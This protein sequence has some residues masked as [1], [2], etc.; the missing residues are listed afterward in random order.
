MG[1]VTLH[2]A[3]R[4]I[5]TCTPCLAL[6]R[7]ADGLT[8]LIAVRIIT[9]PA[10]LGSTRLVIW[11][12]TCTLRAANVMS[13]AGMALRTP[14]L[15]EHSLILH[16][17]TSS[18]ESWT[19]L[20]QGRI[21]TPRDRNAVHGLLLNGLTLL[22]LCIRGLE[23]MD[24]QGTLHEIACFLRRFLSFPQLLFPGLSCRRQSTVAEVTLTLQRGSG[25]LQVPFIVCD[26][27][28]LHPVALCQLCLVEIGVAKELCPA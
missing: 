26:C 1:L 11:R 4:Q 16:M 5:R 9:L 3:L 12:S 22:L 15:Q 10:A 19:N 20:R 14:A 25:Q 18:H 17:L 28:L 13:R 6:R 24:C 8:N 2:K 27:L 23:L 7:L 21:A